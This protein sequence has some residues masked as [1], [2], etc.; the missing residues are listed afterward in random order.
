MVI[1]DLFEA[2]I[3]ENKE[4]VDLVEENKRENPT[5]LRHPDR[6]FTSIASRLFFLLL[7]AVDVVWGIYSVIRLSVIT[8]T[9]L[10]TLGKFSFLK[11][12]IEKAFLSFKRSL[13]CGLALFVGL[14]AAAFGIM[15]AC[16]Y[17]TMYDKNGVEEVVPSSLQPRFR[18]FFD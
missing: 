2:K 8:L 11:I 6:I 13:V 16:T 3:K 12:H 18:P 9:Y 5:P 4:D 14:F 1:Y 10:I 17:F 15:I 7:F